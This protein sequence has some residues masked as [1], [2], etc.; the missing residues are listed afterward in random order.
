MRI[1]MCQASLRLP[2]CASSDSLPTL[3][4]HTPTTPQTESH[5]ALLLRVALPCCLAYYM[6]L[7]ARRAFCRS[8]VR[9]A[10]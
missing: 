8:A 10:Q 6:E 1:S 5:R 4:P 9:G 3:H 7:C 2:S